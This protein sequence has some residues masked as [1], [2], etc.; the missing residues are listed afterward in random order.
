MAIVQVNN[1]IPAKDVPD[2]QVNHDYDRMGI[3]LT[4]VTVDFTG[5]PCT[6][7]V[8]SGSIIEYDGDTY[9]LD[10]DE[11]FV[12]A[13]DDDDVIRFDGAA[14]YTSSG[15][16]TFDAEKNGFY[17][18]GD[19]T[20]KWYIDQARSYCFLDMRAVIGYTGTVRFYQPNEMEA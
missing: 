1:Y 6:V 8:K 9:E 19:R 15:I 18:G 5:S 16:G 12:A 2:L 20:L 13:A 14:F 11:V 17:S 4:V 3:D 10:A 7:T